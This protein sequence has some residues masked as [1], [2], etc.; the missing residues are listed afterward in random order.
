LTANPIKLLKKNLRQWLEFPQYTSIEQLPIDEVLPDLLLPL[1]SHLFLHSGW[2]VG[3]QQLATD[4]NSSKNNS[5]L[6]QAKVEQILRDQGYILHDLR[7]T[8]KRVRYQMNLFTE[9]YGD[10]YGAYLQDMKAIQEYL[11]DIQD[12]EVLEATLVK[13][14]KSDLEVTLPQLAILLRESRYQAWQK[15]Q[16]MQRRYLN[17]EIRQNFRSTLLHPTIESS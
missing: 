15:W 4:S 17:A 11:G 8:V 10:T 12:S 1:I 3:L 16:L 13:L 9:F 5:H 14:L 7:K 2:Q 6:P